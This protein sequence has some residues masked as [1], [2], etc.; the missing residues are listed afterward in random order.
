MKLKPI[1][2][3]TIVIT[4]A[5]SGIGLTTAR[6]AAEKGAKL[7]LVARNEEALRELSDELSA[8]GAHVIYSVGD[9]ADETVLRRAAEI[10]KANFGGFDTWVNNAGGS[11]YGRVTDVPTADLRQL[12]E[13]NVWG[14]VNGS[15]IAVEHLREKGGALINLGSE[16]SDASV[17]LQTMYSASKHAVKGFTDGLRM[18]LEGDKLPISVTLIKPTAI[19]T[20][21]SE[22]AKNYLPYEPQLP[23]P[24]YAPELVAEAILYCAENPKR[25]FFVGGMAKAHSSL[26]LNT[27][28]AYDKL[29]ELILNSAQNSGE[30][31]PAN[32]ADGLYET[33]SKLKER[34]KQERFVLEHSLYQQTNLHPLVSLG[35]L[36][37]A[38]LG[39]A[40]LLGS[41]SKSKTNGNGQNHLIE[42]KNPMPQNQFDQSE[43]REHAEVVG[44]DGAHVG[45]VD[46]NLGDRIKL[47]KRDAN[48]AGMHHEIPTAWVESVERDGTVRLNKTADEAVKQ[49]TTSKEDMTEFMDS[50]KTLAQRGG[51]M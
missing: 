22:N 43:I 50:L 38:G 36:L 29:N 44:S 28:R 25:D 13:T 4:G 18:E 19:H 34:G 24:L 11:V 14:V 5:T 27:P 48:A 20:P 26:A 30:D 7:V 49:W 1:A 17:P 40:A 39:V 6:M 2:E 16:V 42:A 32:R 35:L 9:V 21:F 37:G 8:K 41:R 10:A 51:S 46:H 12:F 45:T 33:N 31:S 23:P 15:K 3:Q 47:R